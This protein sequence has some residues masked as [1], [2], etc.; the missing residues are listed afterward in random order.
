MYVYIYTYLYTCI[1]QDIFIYIYILELYLLFTTG[2]FHTGEIFRHFF[3][4][5]HRLR[6][7][8]PITLSFPLTLSLPFVPVTCDV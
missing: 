3:A 6:P 8:F 5:A 4:L 1:L 7:P 2:E